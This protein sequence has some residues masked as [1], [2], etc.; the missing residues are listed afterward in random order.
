MSAPTASSAAYRCVPGSLGHD[1]EAML[2]VW[3]G[4]LGERAAMARKFDWF[5]ATSPFGAATAML[6][7]EGDGTPP[8][9]VAT[10]GPRQ[11]LR[12]G[13]PVSG[14]VL[15]DLAVLPNHR[16]MGP[17]L[18]LQRALLEEGARHY[19]LIYGFPNR[20]AVPLFRRLE[21]YAPLGDMVRHGRVLRHGAFLARRLPRWLARPL[22]AMLDLADRLLLAWRSRRGPHSRWTGLDDTAVDALWARSLPSTG[23]VAPRDTRL[24]AWRFGHAQPACKVLALSRGSAA[25]AP[26]TAWFVCQPEDQLLHVRDFWS[27]GGLAGPRR[28][29]VEA[30]LR[31]ARAAGHASVSVE[32]CGSEEALGGWRAARF[33]ERD[34]RPLQG[35]W[36]RGHEAFAGAVYFTAA[37]EDE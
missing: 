18:M 29:E 3:D 24:L 36:L 11:L 30:L 12:D 16:S 1:R 35:A 25:G 20:R 33:R 6:L 7:H 23:L 17:A 34:R 28:G 10:L 19:D 8:V 22:G 13:G 37:D 26:L 21:R 14:A 31:A 5:Y 32:F 27:A 9:G 4:S 2:A 15:A